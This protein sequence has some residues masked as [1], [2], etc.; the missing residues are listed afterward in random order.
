MIE[1]D[2]NLFQ[3][4]VNTIKFLSA[5]AIQ[6]AN[7][8]HPGACWGAADMVMGLWTDFLRYNPRDPGW[9][10]RDRFILSA[11]HASMLLYSMLHLSEFGCTLE[12][13]KQFRQLGSRTPGHPER[14]CVPGVEM[15]TGPLGQGFAHGV[16]LALASRM[17]KTR[18][19]NAAFSPV[20]YR[21]FALVSDGD[22]MEGISSESASLAGHLGLGNMVY[23]YDDNHISIE[24]NTNL[25]FTEDVAE[26]FKAF[27]W[28]TIDVNGYDRKEVRCAIKHGIEENE[29]P[30][31]ILARTVLAHGGFAKENDP[32]AHGSPLGEAVIRQAKEAAGWPVDRPFFVPDEVRELFR[33]VTQEKLRTYNEWQDRFLAFKEQNPDQAR[34]LQ[35]YTDHPIPENLLQ[36]M[37]D[38]VGHAGNATRKHSGKAIIAAAK[39]I[40]WIV[41]GSADL[42]PS[43]NTNIPEAGD[44]TP[45]DDASGAGQVN[46]AGRNMH[47]GI[48]EHA[49]GAIINGM[50]LSGLFRGYGAT[51]LVFSDYLRPALRLAALMDLPSI[52]VF[53]HDSVF[54]GEDGPTHQPIE[55]LSALRMIPN[56]RV[57]RPADGVE[58]AVAWY[59]A[60]T[61]N[62]GPTTLVFTRQ[63]VPAIKRQAGFTPDEVMRG[64]YVVQEDRDFDVIIIATGSEVSLAQQAIPILNKQGIRVRLVSMPE[65]SIFQEQET[66]YQNRIIPTD[67]NKIVTIEAGV[68][69]IWRGIAGRDGLCIGI[70]RFGASAPLH[71][72]QERFGFTPQA[73]ADRIIE[74][75][76]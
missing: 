45:S 51:F 34:I 35:D 17:A 67:S 70:D 12:D 41:G 75:L 69:D 46:Y 29:R 74:Y 6:K 60:I 55:Q 50:T 21:V 57:F 47:F 4:A 5:D 1:V 18:I 27:G 36:V 19:G 32:S 37:L 9:I 64:G 65:L 71:D 20:D 16:G 15:T 61:N 66:E 56:L 13:L 23:L 44:V 48:R 3:K 40:P 52:Y 33:Q 54:L 58:T 76:K 24:G 22:L 68:T 42:A 49:M 25:A 8:G 38:A 62:H 43:C 72:I 73:I 31:L 2:E 59:Y 53:T 26:R 14:G 39:D 11:G 63:S 30:T 7:S 28:Q 10:C